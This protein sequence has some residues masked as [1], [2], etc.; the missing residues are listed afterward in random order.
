MNFTLDDIHDRYVCVSK[1]GVRALSYCTTAVSKEDRE[2]WREL[3]RNN[4]E[5]LESQK[6]RPEAGVSTQVYQAALKVVLK[7]QDQQREGLMYV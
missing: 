3:C 2:T 7:F 6:G 5:Y 4:E 1:D